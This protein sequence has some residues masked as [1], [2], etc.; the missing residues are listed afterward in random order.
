MDKRIPNAIRFLSMDAVQKANSGHPGMPMGMADIASVLFTEFIKINPKDPKWVNRDRFVLSNGHGSMLIYSLLYLLGYKEPSLSDIK[1]FRK[2]GSK[3]PGHPEYKHTIGIETTTGPL[4]QGLGNAVGMA[5]GEKI[6]SNKFGSAMINHYTYVFAGDGCLMEGI[7][8]EA[9]SLAGH[10]NLNKMIVFYDDNDI[11]IDG[12]TSLSFTDDTE[13]RIISYGWEYIKIS[14]HNHNQIRKAIKKAQKSNKPTMIACKTTIGYGSPNKAGSHESHGAALGESEIALTRKKLNWP[15]KP[16][17]IPDDVLNF[18]RKSGRR[19]EAKYNSWKRKL[20]KFKRANEFRSFTTQNITSTLINKIV[21]DF[22]KK[23]SDISKISTRKA[24]QLCLDS[25]NTFIDNTIGGSAD[26]TP[27][28]NTKSKDLSILNKTNFDG[29]YIH[30]GVREHGMA[31]IMNGLSLHSGFIPYGGTFLVFSDYCRPSIRLSSM[32]GAKVIYVMTHD[33]IGLG[34]D[35]P[36]HQPVEHLMS[37]R[38]IPKLKVF[39]PCDL[40][41]TLDC[42]VKALNYNGA[43]VMALSRQDLKVVNGNSKKRLAFFDRYNA[44]LIFG[45]LINRDITFIATGSE[46]EIAYEAA[47]ILYDK[48][49]SATVISIPCVENFSDMGIAKINKILGSGKK[50]YIEAGV[51][52]GWRSFFDDTTDFI[53]V[54]TFGESGPKDDVY[55][56]FDISV[57]SLVNKTIK[58]LK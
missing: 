39:R 52:T 46:V 9:L 25:I 14:G 8:H 41:E 58:A 5:L 31:A 29:R 40:N 16:F 30:Y 57:K 21:S 48:S 4:G 33:S 6:L 55:N 10:L 47:K 28:N 51:S 49:I 13:K 45:D 36:T 22:Y 18:W 53:S 32:M 54:E 56:K 26:L 7:S 50:I 24:S 12:P 1:K 2:V 15:Y 20:K 11:S 23:T 43:S 19:S 35:G 44:N 38:L 17:E 3:T 42:W 37:L 27:S 34:E